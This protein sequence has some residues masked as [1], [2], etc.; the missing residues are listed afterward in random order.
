MLKS[1]SSEV[2]LAPCSYLGRN[3]EELACIDAH[4]IPAP[5][6]D[7]KENVRGY[8]YTASPAI[9]GKFEAIF[10]KVSIFGVHFIKKTPYKER[11]WCID[12]TDY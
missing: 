2:V 12:S 1:A 10:S 9:L 4:F 11:T 8:F 5:S 7:R 6:L 3:R